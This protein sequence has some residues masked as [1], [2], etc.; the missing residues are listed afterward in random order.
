MAIFVWYL[1]KRCA[2]FVIG[3]KTASANLSA[4]LAVPGMLAGVQGHYLAITNHLLD[5]VG[6]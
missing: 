2:V 1:Q 4:F 5:E 3:L 6:G